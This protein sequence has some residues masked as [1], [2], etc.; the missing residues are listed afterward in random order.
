H[1]LPTRPVTHLARRPVCLTGERGSKPLRVAKF[2]DRRVAAE[3]DQGIAQSG[4]A[5]ASDARGRRIEACYPDQFARMTN[6][7]GGRDRLENGACRKAWGSRPQSSATCPFKERSGRLTG[8]G[9]G[10]AWKAFGTP[11]RVWAS[12]A[13]SSANSRASPQAN[14]AQRARRCGHF[15]KSTG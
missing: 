3:P 11:L 13:Q 2:A 5:L 8:R 1:E 7:P 14:R 12:C 6:R 4:R 9:A 10:D 15:G